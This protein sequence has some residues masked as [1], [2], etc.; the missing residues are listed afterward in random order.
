MLGRSVFLKWLMIGCIQVQMSVSYTKS[1]MNCLNNDVSL[2]SL[3]VPDAVQ[4]T[5]GAPYGLTVNP[6]WIIDD[7][8]WYGINHPF[9]YVNGGAV[10]VWGW[11]SLYFTLSWACDYISMLG[12][13]LNHV[14]KRGD[15]YEFGHNADN[16]GSTIHEIAFVYR[17]MFLGPV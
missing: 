5:P 10:E 3:P 8:M 15:C 4:Y 14:S 7:N 6:A 17:F 11:M 12:F 13:K 16:A 9:S 1:K 2:R